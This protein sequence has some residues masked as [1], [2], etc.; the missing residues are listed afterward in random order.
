M[1]LARDAK[2]VRD[3]RTGR[4]FITLWACGLNGGGTGVDVVRQI[5]FVINETLTVPLLGVL[6]TFV[7]IHALAIS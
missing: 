2:K 1:P 3:V 5:C 6:R 7:M 4:M